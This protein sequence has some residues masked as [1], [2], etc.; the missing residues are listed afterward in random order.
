MGT[1]TGY[2]NFT[3][4]AW[5][6]PTA[7]SGSSSMNGIIDTRFGT[8][9][10]TLDLYL[11]GGTAVYY[12]LGT[13]SAST[14]NPTSGHITLS[15]TNIIAINNWYM[16]TLLGVQRHHVVPLCERRLAE[17]QRHT[18]YA[19]NLTLR[20]FMEGSTGTLGIGCY[21]LTP[22]AGSDFH[23]YI[24][25]VSIYNTALSAASVAALYASGT[26]TVSGGSNQ[27]PTLTPV[28]VANGATFDIN[29]VSQ[30]VPSLSDSSPGSG[31]TVTNSNTNNAAGATLTL[32]PS[33]G[34]TSTFSGAIQNGSGMALVMT[35]TG[36]QVLDASRRICGKNLERSSFCSRPISLSATKTDGACF[37]S[38]RCAGL[39][40]H[41]GEFGRVRLRLGSGCTRRTDGP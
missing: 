9:T 17:W 38:T 25:E 18:G 12:D 6:Y 21:G 30:Q 33:D 41:R 5:I 34:G 24:D 3:V 15:G 13:G 7:L 27:L 31:G 19:S 32:S 1:G 4:S 39:L 40:H 20:N 37:E 28:V 2:N 29:G 36:T 11:S 22:A 35:G 14:G 16:I 8:Y 26:A 23:G 10:A